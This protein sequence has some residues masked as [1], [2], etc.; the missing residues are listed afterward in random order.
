MLVLV[1][2][3][4]QTRVTDDNGCNKGLDANNELDGEI[5]CT[6]G[7]GTKKY[8]G[9]Y[10]HG[11]RVGL[12][13]SWRQNGKLASVDRFVDGKREGLCEEYGLDGFLTEACVYKADVKEGLCKLYGREGKLREERLYVAGR[14]RGAFTEYWPSG[15]VLERGTIDENG[16]PDGLKERFRENGAPE[17]LITFV[18]GE[19]NGVEREWHPSGKLRRETWWK[20]DQQHGLMKDFHESG[21]PQS[22]SCYQDG[23]L[24]TGTNPCTGKSGPEVVTRFFPEG[25]PYETTA[26]KNGKRNGEHQQFDRDGKLVFS[27]R[28]V[29]DVR[30]GPQREFKAGVLRHEQN[31]VAG[32]REGVEKRFFED[33]KLAEEATWKAERKV[34]LTTYW[35]NGKKKLVEKSDG[36]VL[37]R[38]RWYDDGTQE[39]E[40]TLRVG[41]DREV[42]EGPARAWSEKGTLVEVSSWRSGR[43][44]GTQKA[45]FAKTGAPYFTEE[46]SE[47]T[48]RS[49][50]EWGEDGAVVKDEKYNADGSRQ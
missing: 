25:K 37:V 10:A 1:A 24:V 39:A 21:G 38:T 43:R 34:A 16:R 36:E 8:E 47:G 40:E 14:Q 33:G 19:R 46:W 15:K 23:K 5:V 31:F 44:D 30:D 13:K 27:E 22:E 17:S 32:K 9:V 28:F 48:R 49:R 11:K 26:V 6:F 41:Y 45:F 2:A 35:M 4:A 20:K 29:D 7:D 3:P 18:H 50:I 42:R 12:A